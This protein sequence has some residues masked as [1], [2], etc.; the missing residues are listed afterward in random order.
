MTTAGSLSSR[1][2]DDDAVLVLAALEAVLAA[3]EAVLVLRLPAELDL[4]LLLANLLDLDLDLEE[5]PEESE[6]LLLLLSLAASTDAAR[7]LGGDGESLLLLG[8]RMRRL[9]GSCR[10]LPG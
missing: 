5:E 9:A 8:E 2:L 4:V 3:L 10:P 7:L 6:E 1:D